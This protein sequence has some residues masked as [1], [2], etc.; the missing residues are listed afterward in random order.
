MSCGNLFLQDPVNRFWILSASDDGTLVTSQTPTIPPNFTPPVI[1]SPSFFWRL[2][3]TVNGVIT[4]TS[5]GAT[6]ASSFYNLSSINGKVFSLTMQDNGVLLT[7]SSAGA[8]AGIL[9]P[10][11]ID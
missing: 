8:L 11:P 5:V 4:A 1:T 7:T 10:Y 6:A 9:V 2:S 3:S